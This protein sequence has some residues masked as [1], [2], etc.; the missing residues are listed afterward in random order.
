MDA[1]NFLFLEP[2]VP[3]ENERD[4]ARLLL[5]FYKQMGYQALAVGDN[6]LAGSVPFLLKEAERRGLLLLSANLRYHGKE[7]VAPYRIFDAGKVRVGVIAVTSP[8]ISERLRNEG[9]EILKPI[10]RLKDL[11]PDIRH[12]SDVVVLLSN[13][14]EPEDRRLARAV[15]GIDVIIGSGPGVRRY[16]PLKVGKTFLLR[17]HPK[18]KTIGVAELELGDRGN[19]MELRNELIFMHPGCPMDQKAV[20]RINALKSAPGKNAEADGMSH[21]VSK[22]PSIPD[23]QEKPDAVLQPVSSGHVQKP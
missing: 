3:T 5:D 13:L 10:T 7:V 14:G 21:S 1:G 12:K 17:T 11:V 19:S 2:S 4:R 15:P 23:A 8:D 20:R 9:I 16:M 6:D 22:A 18:G